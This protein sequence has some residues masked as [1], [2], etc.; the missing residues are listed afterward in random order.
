MTTSA[1]KRYAHALIRHFIL[2]T[3]FFPIF[4]SKYQHVYY[5]DMSFISILALL[6]SI[7]IFCRWRLDFRKHGFSVLAIAIVL[8]TYVIIAMVN[9]KRYPV[10]FWRTEPLNVLIAVVFFLSLLLLRD[11]TTVISDKFL[12]FTIIAILIH[13]V[14]GIIFRLTGGAKFYMQTLFY[15]ARTIEETDGVFSWLYYD[16]SEYALMLL[17]SMAFFMTY[18]RLFKN[19][20]LY[21]ASQGLLIICMLLT[22]TSIY[23]LA[24]ALLFGFN[25]LY[26]LV[27]KYEILEHCVSYSYPILIAICGVGMYLLTRFL[28]SL[29]TKAL[30][31]KGTWDILRVQPEGLY[32][33]FGYAPYQVPGVDV[34]L[35]QAQNTF[36]NHMLRHSVG[37][38]LVF[39]VLI[40]TIFI[41]AFIKKPQLRSLGILLAILIPILTE[42]GLQ[43]LY[44]PYVLF[45]M[46]CIFF[47]KGE[48]TDAF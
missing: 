4:Y 37:T 24:T 23:Y 10:Y 15:E 47:K 27:R 3:L 8:L 33:S 39:T 41:I 32:V 40:L 31:W 18:R 14:C 26:T 25:L 42:F 7:N 1:P 13:N 44:L 17:L 45:L 22:N 38:G 16:A 21:W 2:I 36:L 29:Q 43:T 28:P 30:I 5:Q 11:E 19:A 48:S 12:R 35:I 34:P 6:F 9:Y 20:Y 46:Y